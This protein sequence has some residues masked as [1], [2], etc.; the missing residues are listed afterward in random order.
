MNGKQKQIMLST[1]ICL[2]FTL[3]SCGAKHST[4]DVQ[5]S[6][7]SNMTIEDTSGDIDKVVSVDTDEAADAQLALD[8]YPSTAEVLACIDAGESRLYWC[9]EK[10][11]TFDTF[12]IAPILTLEEEDFTSQLSTILGEGYTISLNTEVTGIL[13]ASNGT[14][15]DDT[16]VLSALSELTGM[17]YTQID[18]DEQYI[19]RYVPEWSGICVDAEGYPYGSTGDYCPGIY[20]GV[21][22]DGSVYIN[23]SAILGEGQK[24]IDPT[25]FVTPDTVKQ[26]CQGYYENY[27]I[28]S[29]VVVTEIA[30]G[31]YY[32]EA[33]KSLLPAWVCATTLYMSENG[34]N[35]SV[36]IDAQT[37]E[38][39][40]K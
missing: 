11:E 10:P 9:A 6:D 39:L 31:C 4:S 28:P 17:K 25:T 13:V 37:G 8:K 1:I 15:T 40:R 20:V 35:D 34:H 2:I 7:M 29:A 16:E 21:Q 36:L 38:L 33:E 5:T 3:S 22:A 24:Q 32:S 12:T 27:G 14:T 26:L 19:S 23:R 30:P 18:S